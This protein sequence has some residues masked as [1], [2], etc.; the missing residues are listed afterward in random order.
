VLC[1]EINAV[2]YLKD[3]KL[4]Y[5]GYRYIILNY[6]A[7]STSVSIR[8]SLLDGKPRNCNSIT[9]RTGVYLPSPEWPNWLWGLPRLICRGTGSSYTM[10]KMAGM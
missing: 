1:R 6:N 4:Y 9:G 5:V 2:H 3:M 10:S 7:A 8:T